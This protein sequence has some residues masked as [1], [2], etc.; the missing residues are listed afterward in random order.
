MV[1][2]P[3]CSS[4]IARSW[5]LPSSGIGQLKELKSLTLNG[6]CRGLTDETLPYL[7][8]LTKLEELAT[9]GIQV[10]DAGL[11]GFA[12]LTN[13][14]SLSFF[15]PSFGMQG[16]DGSGFAAL[17]SLARLERLTIAGT[18]FDDK[19][20]VAVAQIAQL[21]DFRTWHTYQ[22][23]AGNE[24]LAKL[25]KLKS[26]WL[27]QRLRRYDVGSNAASLDDSTLALLAKLTTLE[28]VT[29]DEARLSLAALR[30]LQELPR[31]RKLELR[32]IDKSP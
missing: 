3:R 22:S 4:K 8:G 12:A 26:L 10:T 28:T 27:G 29:L 30:Q 1:S 7:S 11:A 20:M 9:D 25:P 2:S 19:G 21:Q 24:S 5:A 17:K 14:R 16:F 23:S 32:R 31:L 15:H 18:P 13:L 6:Q